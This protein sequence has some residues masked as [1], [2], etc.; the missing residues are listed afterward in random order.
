MGFLNKLGLAI[1]SQ[2]ARANSAPLH[3]ERKVH[4]SGGS[5]L[6]VGT[7]RPPEPQ[8]SSRL[9]NGL[10]EFLWNLDGLGHGTL[11]DLGPAWQT[12][13]TFFIERG[14][15]VTSDDILRDWSEFLVEDDAKARENPT[16]E[17]YAERTPEFR[18]KRFLD[19][20]LQYPLASFDALLLWD[21]LDYIEPTLAKLI[22]SH[23]TDLLRPGGVVF[24]MFHSKKPTGFQRYRVADTNTLQVLSAK[25]IFPAQ[26]VYQN[27]E[28]Q[29]LFGR[30]RSM[31]SFISRDQLRETLFIK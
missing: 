16:P 29:E 24:A 26:K 22:I 14:F 10:K 6:A 20:N 12:T 2:T 5:S 4:H 3:N 8:T 11:L 25:E 21:V 27:R 7:N 1:G 15:R 17:L 13:L 18:A 19:Q 9:S 30:F 31:K 28:I 23:L